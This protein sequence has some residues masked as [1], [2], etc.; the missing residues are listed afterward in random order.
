MRKKIRTIGELKDSRLLYD[1]DVPAFGYM[2]VAVVAFV[3]IGIIIW[4]VFATKPYMIKASGTVTSENA[5]YVMAAVAGT[6][7]ESHM[8]EGLVVQRGDVLFAVESTDYDMQI[9]QLEE[10]RD[11]YLRQ[12]QQYKKLVLSI[13]DDTNYFS[14]TESGDGFYYSSFEAYK[15][16]VLQN[17]FDASTY[18]AYGYSDEQIEFEIEKNQ[19]KT[20]EIY[21][22]AI[23]SA[24][25]GAKE[26]QGQIAAIE[27]QLA[28]LKA[29][30]GTYEVTASASGVL[31]LLADYKP[32]MVVQAGTAVAIITSA[33]EDTIVEAYITPAGRVKISTGDEVKIAVSGLLQSV[34]GTISGRVVQ[35]D[36]NSTTQ[37][38][39]ED[40]N[41][42]F[43]K[44][45][46]KPDYC[47]VT[48]RSGE[49]I[50]LSSGMAVEARIQYDKVTYFNYVMEKLGV[51]VR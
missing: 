49:K 16:Q 23:Q 9:Q 13:K 36:S 31:H 4:S 18:K 7:S 22:S 11:Y 39:K 20:V 25:N 21:H 27:A 51:K 35:I 50:D 32:G 29:G 40:G 46:V 28:A 15:A 30:K 47:Y 5:N 26:C 41:T 48:S 17:R 8:T 33:N 45:K 14:A 37:E 10:N 1:K 43:F 44:V 2:I 12:M 34:Y 3:S 6:L 42:T 38:G 24:E 19:A